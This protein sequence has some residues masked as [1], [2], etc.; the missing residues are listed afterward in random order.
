MTAAARHNLL[1]LRASAVCVQLQPSRQPGERRLHHSGFAC[2]K[3]CR[4]TSGSSGQRPTRFLM[5]ARP[6]CKVQVRE[7]LSFRRRRKSAR[8]HAP[9]L[10]TAAATALTR[11]Q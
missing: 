4:Q 2:R 8:S 9:C 7:P 5:R 3:M 6:G 1:C 11:Q 10:R